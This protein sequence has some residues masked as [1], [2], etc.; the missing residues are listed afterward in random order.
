MRIIKLKWDN[1]A[2]NFI[3]HLFTFKFDMMY[4]P[5]LISACIFAILAVV[6]GAF[7]AHKLKTIMSP[8]LLESFETGVR[9]QFYHVFAL[10]L[11]GVLFMAFPS[12][13]IVYATWFFNLGIILFSGSIY[14]LTIMKSTQDI[15]L[16]KFGLVT[17][18]GGLL[19]I[20]GW[21]T[22]LLALF[23]KKQ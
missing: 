3:N 5:A 4:K 9:Y 18:I 11:A 1:F 7:G 2:Q 15:G 13:K 17:P 22:L 10:A 8:E 16:G 12:P 21:I 14:L 6:I 20:I 19:F 23:E